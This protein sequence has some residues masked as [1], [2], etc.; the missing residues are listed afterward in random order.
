MS[1]SAE[2]YRTE[3]KQALQRRQDSWERS[4]TDGFL[5]QWA[6][7]LSAQLASKKAEIVENG[8]KAEFA[9]LYEGTRRVM[10]RI[11]QTQ[12]GSC[13]LLH[14][15]EA[16]LMAKRGSRFV[17]TGDNS[18]IQKRLGLSQRFE[19][20]PAWAKMDGRGTGLSGQ[21]W[22]AVFRTG[23]KWGKDAELIAE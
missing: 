21:A 4:D 19:M 20:A 22:V 16:D 13:W 10:A 15:S 11:I 6:S 8:N 18:R 5:T 3:A 12:Y 2:D 1:K 23:D 7:G 14:D 17:P 9:G